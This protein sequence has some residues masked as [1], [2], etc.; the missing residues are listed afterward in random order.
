MTECFFA[1]G[2]FVQ[3]G[4]MREAFLGCFEG[5]VGKALCHACELEAFQE[6]TQFVVAID[7]VRH[8]S[9]LMESVDRRQTNPAQAPLSQEPDAS[10]AA[11]P[12]HVPSETSGICP[13]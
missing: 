12:G 3:I 10:L 6:H 2:Y 7:G 8:S 13:L 9:S 11:A 4:F 5:Q 1:L